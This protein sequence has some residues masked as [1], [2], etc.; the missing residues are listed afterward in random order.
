MAAGERIALYG[1]DEALPPRVAFTAGPFTFERVGGR[2]AHLRVQGHEVWHGFAFLYRDQHW[3]TPEPLFERIDHAADPD[4]FSLTLEGHIPARPPIQLSLHLRCDAG[5]TLH[6]RSRAVPAGDLDANRIGL[7]LLYPMQ[8]GGCAVEVEHVDGRISRSTLPAHVP[9]WPPFT[10]VRALRHEYAPGHWADARLTG[11]TFE[12]ED[13]RN[14]ADASFKIYSR[15]NL[16]PR[17]YR[18]R[19]GAAIEQSMRLRV[20]S[21]APRIIAPPPTVR[22]GVSSVPAPMPCLAIGPHDA[23]AAE[24]VGQALAELRPALLHLMLDAA[25]QPMDWQ[26]IARLLAIADA[27][28]RLDI[29]GAATAD[30]LRAL[31]GRL[32]A[33]GIA[34]ESVAMFP[35]TPPALETL[36]TLFPEALVGG[37]TPHFF[38][39]F[40][41]LEDLGRA[42][43]LSF[44]VCP[45]V[46]DAGDAG[47]MSGLRS[48]PSMLAS[49]RACHPGCLLRIGPSQIGARASPLGHQPETDG[50]R[51]VAL[52][53]R[54]PRT[55]GLFGAA[56]L[57]GHFAGAVRGGAEA[58]T[59][60]ALRG[61][62]GLLDDDAGGLRRHPAFFV[63]A[64]IARWRRMREVEVND[65]PQ[66]TA[67]AGER[68]G[69]LEMLVANLS[70]DTLEIAAGSWEAVQLMDARAWQ[71]HAERGVPGAWRDIEHRDGTLRLPPFAT[72]RLATGLA[73]SRAGD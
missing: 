42:D 36:R 49:A 19:G 8:A 35:G 64:T 53:R 37:G 65:S 71:A 32:R 26:G 30:E 17:P 45:I 44:T 72:A 25:A 56:W 47:V 54:D 13:Q 21:L 41:R 55:R 31:A 15:S 20:E 69:R 51:R 67:L 3:G 12:L 23:S 46:H 66:V 48:L 59:A 28:L 16:M 73:P 1:T 34:P 2:F 5:G 4:G 18:L 68:D 10:L 40:N 52:A 43:F 33:A 62:A 27:R 38:A 50:L 39:Q 6:V 24:P 22:V 57:L 63:W 60:M 7:C 11:D 70:S 29:H 61:D 14:N 9:P 58:V